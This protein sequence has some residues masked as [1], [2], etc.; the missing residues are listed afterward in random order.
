MSS[1]A[2]AIRPR[3]WMGSVVGGSVWIVWLVSLALGGWYRDADGQ[4]VGADHLAVY[5]AAHLIRA[6][7]PAALYDHEF[8][9]PYQDLLVGWDYPGLEAFRNPPFYALLYVPTAG[10]SYYIS[11]VLWTVI[12]FALL[13]GAILLLR[14]TQPLRV[15]SWALV[16]YPVFAT[17]SFGQNTFLSLIVFAGVYRLLEADR[18]LIAGLVAG[19]LW[20]KPQL[21]IGFMIWWA[22]SPARYWRCWLGIG[23][24]GLALAGLSWLVLPEASAA[25]VH[26]LREN[27]GYGGEGLWNKHSPRAFFQLLLPGA[28][29]L[30]WV[31]TASV[32][33]LSIA[34]VAWLARRSGSSV[35]T[36]FPV[37]VFLSLWVTPHALIYEWALLVVAGVILWERWP[38]SRDVWLGLFAFAW[39]ALTIST[40]LTS[41]QLRYSPFAVQLSIPVMGVVGGLTLRELGRC[42]VTNE[43]AGRPDALAGTRY[44]T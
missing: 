4:L 26:S 44:R 7:Q 35:A 24:T 12:G 37:A 42:G 17:V 41:I 40:P 33:M 8:L 21:L 15:L 14:P 23:L 25:F 18:Y 16:F 6:G 30:A 3:L 36:M 32:W 22:V 43:Q 2:T 9:A 5:S 28:P 20:F 31:L 39:L 19:L 27:V 1:L 34:A 10:L 11:Y 29:L 13:V 38:G